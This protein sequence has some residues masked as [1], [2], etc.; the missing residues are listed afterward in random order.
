M[1]VEASAIG[2]SI[3]STIGRQIVLQLSVDQSLRQSLFQLLAFPLLHY[4]VINSAALTI[5]ASGGK[6]FFARFFNCVNFSFWSFL[7]VWSWDG[8]PINCIQG[9]ACLSGSC[10]PGMTVI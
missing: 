7:M 5:G 1:A 9:Q 2:G 6:P 4:S 3:A 8:I 10:S